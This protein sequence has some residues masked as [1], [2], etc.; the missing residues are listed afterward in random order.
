MPPIFAIGSSHVR[1]DLT[2]AAGEAQEIAFT[3][4]AGTSNDEALGLA[5]QYR[6]LMAVHQSLDEVRRYWQG[7]TTALKVESP[8]AELNMMANGWLQYQAISA[9]IKGRTAYYQTG[10]AYGFRDQLQDSLLWL[11]LGQP[12]N[13][14]AKDRWDRAISDVID[15]KIEALKKH[16]SQMGEWDPTEMVK[17]WS[18]EAAKGKEMAY[19]EAFRV[20]TL[21]S[22]EDF[23]KLEKM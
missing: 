15:L 4:G 1:I 21:V 10:G 18:A 12:E 8:D 6:E 11:L 5:A 17:K 3:L 9:R 19:A 2:L 14:A 20:V 7:I 13:Q 23:A 16:V 22:D